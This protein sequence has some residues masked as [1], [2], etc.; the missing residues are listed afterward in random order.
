MNFSFIKTELHLESSIISETVTPTQDNLS[1]YQEYLSQ[2]SSAHS[3]WSAAYGIAVAL[4]LY[5]RQPSVVSLIYLPLF[6]IIK[7]YM[8]I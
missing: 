1:S 6:G 4:N 2:R 5:E 3:S 8:I 7:L